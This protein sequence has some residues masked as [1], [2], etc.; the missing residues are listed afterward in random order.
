M[1]LDQAFLSRLQGLAKLVG[2]DLDEDIVGL[3]DRA[4]A[5]LGYDRLCA[6]LDK[7][8]E[9]ATQWPS[10]KHIREVVTGVRDAKVLA[11]E[12]LDD[13]RARMAVK[14]IMAAVVKFGACPPPSR[15][16]ELVASIDP[17]GWE[18]VKAHGGWT[19]LCECLDS[20]HQGTLA[21]QMREQAKAE[22][23]AA[24]HP[25][26]MAGGSSARTPIGDSRAMSDVVSPIG[27]TDLAAALPP[28]LRHLAKADP[29]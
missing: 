8:A 5:P 14:S 29:E 16:E 19:Y 1:S 23:L 2:F 11:P 9:G 25:E 26:L 12:T 28:G 27:A 10:I 15:R 18:V 13:S 3:Y 6:A 21:A 4:L 7:I 17:L 22:I 20:D 24:R